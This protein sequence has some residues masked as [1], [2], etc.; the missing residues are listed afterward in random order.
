MMDKIFDP[1]Q[2]GRSGLKNS[3]EALLRRASKRVL[4]TFEVLNR[5]EFDA[6]W[7]SRRNEAGCA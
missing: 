3:I 1:T 7:R 2:S 5:I 6:P 4:R